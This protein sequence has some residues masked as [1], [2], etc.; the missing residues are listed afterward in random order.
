MTFPNTN[1]IYGKAH[2]L[3]GSRI[4][5]LQQELEW[6]EW[7]KSSSEDLGKPEISNNSSTGKEY[8]CLYALDTSQGI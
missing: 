1:N 5:W 8:S 3:C 4:I 6:K 7:K 2:V